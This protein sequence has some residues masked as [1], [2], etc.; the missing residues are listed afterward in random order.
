MMMVRSTS[1]TRLAMG[2][3]CL[4]CIFGAFPSSFASTEKP[5]TAIVYY[6]VTYADGSVR[7]LN[8]PPSTNE[9]IRQVLRLARYESTLPS[10]ETLSTGAGASH[11]VINPGRTIRQ[12]LQWNGRAWTAPKS[13]HAAATPATMPL[14]ELARQRQAELQLLQEQL[15]R[16]IRELAELKKAIS[17]ARRE[18][19]AA[20]GTSDEAA[21][22]KKL[23]SLL[24]ARS[25][26][27]KSVRALQK[28]LDLVRK[29]VPLDHPTGKVTPASPLPGRYWGISRPVQQRRLLPYQVQVWKLDEAEGRR[30]YVVSMA[31]SDAGELGAFYYVA[32]ADTD[33]DGLPDKLIAHS[34]LAQADEP[35]QWTQWSFSTS[36][37]RVFVGNAWPNS[38]TAV[39]Y[40]PRDGTSVSWDGLGTEV[41]FSGYYGGVPWQQWRYAPYFTNL[42]VYVPN[43]NPDVMSPATGSRITIEQR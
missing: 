35:G 8:A 33:D 34:P 12:Y 20:K 15:A 23:A 5:V 16:H 36:A 38:N 29:P 24:A 7:D 43:Q 9:N 27:R 2:L 31:H 6:Q 37:R 18:L 25:K 10:Y 30:T 11:T 40:Q 22:E 32:Y 3:I 14:G 39:Y 41:Y 13:Q 17:R 26:A 28:S 42:R 1:L 19:A 21:A 4:L